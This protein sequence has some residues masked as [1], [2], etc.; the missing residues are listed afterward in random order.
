MLKANINV[1]CSTYAEL[2]AALYMLANQ[3]DYEDVTKVH[4]HRS[5]ESDL[6]LD[7]ILVE[8]REEKIN[9]G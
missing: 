8:T 4:M 3:L 2:K 9:N 5:P 6:T 1:R 7:I